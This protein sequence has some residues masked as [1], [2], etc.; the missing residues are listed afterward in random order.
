MNAATILTLIRFILTPIFI[1]A[2]ALNQK[3]WAILLFSVAGFTDLIDG[4]IARLL[5]QHSAKGAV[6]DPLADKFLMQSCFL[7]LFAS[8]IVP[9]WFVLLA[10]GRDLMIVVGIF[11]LEYRKV[12][13]PYGATISSKI[14]T[15]FQLAVAIMGLILWWQPILAVGVITLGRIFFGTLLATT[16]LLVVSGTQYV[17]IGLRILHENR[18][19]TESTAGPSS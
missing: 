6:L 3:V 14:A 4:T 19:R 18:L 16:L 1:I 11:Y 15:L 12:P 13:L 7:C 8:G 10:L 2:F 5:K 9:W 17:I